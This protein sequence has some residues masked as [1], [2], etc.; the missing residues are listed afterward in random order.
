MLPHHGSLRTSSSLTCFPSTATTPRPCPTSVD[1]IIV[2]GGLAGTL[3]AILLS[4]SS[5]KVALIDL[6]DVYPADFRAE[7][8]VGSQVSM[9]SRLDLLDSVV[10]NVTPA[11]KA[12]ATLAGRT[13]DAAVAPHYGIRYESMVNRARRHL[14]S[15]VELIAAR[16]ADLEL[17]QDRQRVI[18]S[19]GNIVE[20]RLI[21]MATGPGQRLL[22][23]IGI[24]RQVVRQAHSLAFGFDFEVASPA[25]F[26][27]LVLVAYG[28]KTEDRIDYLS[29]FAIADKLRAN[30]FT[31]GQF[32]DGW[33]KKLLEHPG[34]T[35][36][37]ALPSLEQMTGPIKVAGP[38]EVRVNDLSVTAGHCREGVVLIG[39]AFQTSC[40][41]A[42]TGVSR[43]LNDIEV[44]CNIY[45]PEW[46]ASPGMDAQKIGAFYKDPIKRCCDA[47]ALR[48]ANY[49]RALTTESSLSWKIHRRRVL[50]QKRLALALGWRKHRSPINVHHDGETVRAGAPAEDPAFAKAAKGG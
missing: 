39:D 22:R 33:T 37:Q 18:L 36:R 38:V 28:E 4:R 46:F 8:L 45:I 7:Q 11:E 34:D 24:N 17:S 32:R 25:A 40:P 48:V 14:P 12:V 6:H 10:G 15:S 30:M 35:L 43:L 44:L 42:G 29:L 31:Y 20:G 3:A 1:V 5:L 23:Q 49:R 13:V 27:A 26:R 41:A 47:E 21:V 2:G 16:V 50:W 19:T 9:L